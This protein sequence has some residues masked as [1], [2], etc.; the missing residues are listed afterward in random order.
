[1]HAIGLCLLLRRLRIHVVV[2]PVDTRV[3]CYARN[4]LFIGSYVLWR[5]I[6]TSGLCL[7]RRHLGILDKLVVLPDNGRLR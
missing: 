7:L 1:M 5:P 4:M 6:P 3:R 2:L